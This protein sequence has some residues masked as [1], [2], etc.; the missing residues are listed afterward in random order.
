MSSGGDGA[1]RR[2]NGVREGSGDARGRTPIASNGASDPEMGVFHRNGDGRSE[3]VLDDPGAFYPGDGDF[4]TARFLTALRAAVPV[5]PDPAL[6]AEMIPALAS[7]ARAATLESQRASTGVIAAPPESEPARAPVWGWRRRLAIAAAA[8]MLLPVLM[9]SLAYAGVELPAPVDD[10]FEAVGVDLPSQASDR[11]TDGR[12]GGRGDDRAKDDK[13]AAGTDDTRDGSPAAGSDDAGAGKG[14]EGNAT[15][16]PGHA[17]QEAAP[18]GQDGTPPGHGGE[19][20]G[21]G[22]VP[23]APEPPGPPAEP[24]PPVTPPGQG[25]VPPGQGSVPP[26]QGGTPPGQS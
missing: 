13:D 7:A 4:E 24:A 5:A 18:P 26:G 21:T 11:A 12:E 10:A 25:G 16:Q 14:N 9:A 8:V 23:P 2:S 20:P 15:G 19:V 17:G 3:R 1:R 6:E 22:D